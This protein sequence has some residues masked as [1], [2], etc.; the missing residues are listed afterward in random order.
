L[1]DD[2]PD[3]ESG[4]DGVAPLRARVRHACWRRRGAAA[5]AHAHRGEKLEQSAA[6]HLGLP[7]LFVPGFS[8]EHRSHL[9]GRRKCSPDISV[10]RAD[11]E[12]N[13]AI[14]MLAIQLEPIADPLRP[15][16]ENLRAFRAFDPHFFIGHEKPL[17]ESRESGS[18][19]LRARI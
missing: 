12:R 14:A 8:I 11:I 10:F 7:Q 16:S 5:L 9:F 13:E 3:R 2:L 6:D 17:T 18:V 15:L 19:D 1:A 4:G